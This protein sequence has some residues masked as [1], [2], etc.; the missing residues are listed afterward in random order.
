MINPDP[1]EV[2]VFSLGSC[3]C[4]GIL[5]GKLKKSSK[6]GCCISFVST[7]PVVEIFTTEGDNFS[8]RV[9][10]VLGSKNAF[11]LVELINNA[12]IIKCIFFLVLIIN[13]SF[14]KPNYN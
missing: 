2:K 6:V 9:E 4:L 1:S 7:I 13:L 11:E 8:A 12:I 14:Y 10:K 3:C 5:K